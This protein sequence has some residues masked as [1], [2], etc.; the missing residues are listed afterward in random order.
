MKILFIC[1]ANICRSPLAEVILKKM[2]EERGITDIEVESAGI[3]NYE[4][5]TRDPTM[6]NYAREAGYEMTGTARFATR[7]ILESADLIICMEHFHA[8]NL[9]RRLPPERWG[10]I[11]TFNEICF[12]IQTDLPDPHGKSDYDYRYAFS[13]IQQGCDVL[14]QKLQGKTMTTLYLVRHGETV[15]NV[16][17]IL[18]GQQQGELTPAGIKQ[19]E[20]L[21]VS[22]SD[23]HFDAI[24]SSDLRRAYDSALIIG[25][26]LDLPVQTTPLLRERDW[27][28]FTGRFIPEL[29]GLPLP[30][31]VEEMKALLNRAKSFL[32]WAKTN[33]S[34]KTVLA[35]GHGIINKAIQSVH[36]GK[37]T[38]KIPKMSNAEYRVLYL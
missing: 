3:H 6:V 35:V 21:A 23:I 33:Y 30:D 9:Q 26:H 7:A 31:N 20:E 25:R 28:D 10:C 18:Q 27:G 14:I 4:G 38:R 36:Y 5:Y 22:L 19:I 13:K 8:E 29:D 1:Y 34:G 24:V 32:E 37:L 11:H 16:G 2:L 12:N 17:K 15:D